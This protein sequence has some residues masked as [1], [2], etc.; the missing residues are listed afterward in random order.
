MVNH[1]LLQ[2]KIRERW[3]RYLRNNILETSKDKME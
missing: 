2:G 3:H 1:I